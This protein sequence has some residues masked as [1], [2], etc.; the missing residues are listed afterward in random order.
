MALHV[1]RLANAQ[2]AGKEQQASSC[3]AVLV[4]YVFENACNILNTTHQLQ[5]FRLG[6]NL[7]TSSS[8]RFGDVI[9]L[10]LELAAGSD[11]GMFYVLGHQSPLSLVE[12]CQDVID[13]ILV[14]EKPNT[15]Q[16]PSDGAVA[17]PVPVHSREYWFEIVGKSEYMMQQMLQKLKM[18]LHHLE[19]EE[20]TMVQ[21]N[22]Q[23]EERRPSL[24]IRRPSAVASPGGGFTSPISALRRRSQDTRLDQDIELSEVHVS[25]LVQQESTSF[26]AESPSPVSK[27]PVP[28]PA[29]S[30]DARR[31]LEKRIADLEDLAN[32]EAQR[33]SENESS[34]N[35]SAV[36]YGDVVQLRHVLSKKFVALA[37]GALSSYELSDGDMNC[38]FAF[39]PV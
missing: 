12:G 27:T 22:G 14:A 10:G 11:D 5:L 30:S 21:S 9:C 31:R 3:A 20:E 15:F 2:G 28:K 18:Q 36:R 32:G 7:G 34:R 24:S 4:Q 39:E 6:M 16:S 26:A 8:L 13:H 23:P 29:G 17:F 35:G 1:C 37:S 33:N 38:W 19:A 25:L